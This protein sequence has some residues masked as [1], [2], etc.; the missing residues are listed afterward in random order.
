MSV[1]ITGGAGF[2]GAN[3]VERF[4][5]ET[6][7]SEIRIFD[8]FSTGIRREY[9]D[10]RVK[11]IEGDLRNQDE[12]LSAFAG[13]H[14][15]VHLG[16]LPSVPRSIKDPRSSLDVN[17]IGTLNVLEA[18]RVHGLEH[19]V[20]ASSSSVY[21]ANPTLPKSEGLVPQPVS[22]YAV[23]KLA[24]ESLTN[25]YLH[26][27]GLPTLAFRFFNVF[28]PLQRA[29]HAYAAVVPLFIEALKQ[30]KPLTVYGDG[31]QSRDF[32]SVHVVVD[33][34]AKASLRKVTY[35]SPVNL[36]FGTRTTLNEAIEILRKIH[37]APIGVDYTEPRPGDVRHSQASSSLLQSLIHDLRAPAL[38]D[39]LR[40]VYDWYFQSV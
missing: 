31:E 13:V 34:L 8:D 26:S 32:T 14:R 12:V 6:E 17:V 2:I 15:V 16:A 38:P 10:P 18:A 36:A 11:V 19:V 25:S 29:D 30:G 1:A 21:G 39:A 5:E 23:S 27:Y 7:V 24:T 3:L 40:E 37:P 4:M 9:V 28:G 22:P 33:A 35:P 20:S